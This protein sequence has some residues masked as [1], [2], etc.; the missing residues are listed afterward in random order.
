MYYSDNMVE[1]VIPDTRLKGPNIMLF[2]V[3]TWRLGKLEH[4]GLSLIMFCYSV[5]KNI[6]TV[7]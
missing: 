7:P 5:F 1:D 6:Y 2:L 3:C 4:Q